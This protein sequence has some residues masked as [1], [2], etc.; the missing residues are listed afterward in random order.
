MGSIDRE[1]TA[2]RRLKPC[3]FC[4]GVALLD[5]LN[6]ERMI[7]CADCEDGG[8]VGYETE[9]ELIEAWNRRPK[10]E[11]FDPERAGFK[12]DTSTQFV[13][14]DWEVIRRK[15]RGEPVWTFRFWSDNADPEGF[16]LPL[17]TPHDIAVSTIRVNGYKGGE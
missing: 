15:E 1:A 5:Y 12:M 16:N 3:P 10:I 8:V 2:D 6:G 4:G 11:T 9:E 17:D 14:G 7:F 13:S